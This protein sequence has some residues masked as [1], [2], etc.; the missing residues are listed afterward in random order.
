MSKWQFLALSTVLMLALYCRPVLSEEKAAGSVDVHR[1]VRDKW[2]LVVGVG[3]Y[4][5]A[6]VPKLKFASKDARDFRNFLVSEAHFAPDH[7]RL[8]LDEQA[9]QRRVLSE[10]GNK[11]LARVARPDDLVV[12]YFSSHGSASQADIRGRNFIVAYDTDPEDLFTT[13]IE[14]DK[15]VESI[16]S[17]VLSDRVLLVLDA[18]HSGAIAAGSKGLNRAGNFDAEQ[19]AQGTGQLVIC[20][21]Q[22]DQQSWESKR[23]DNGIFTRKLL[24]GLRLHGKSTRLD[25]AYTHLK[26]SVAEEVQQDY[27][28]R[29]NPSLKSFWKGDDLVLALLPQN[30]QPVPAAV[31][32]ILEP[33]STAV[34]PAGNVPPAK[35]ASAAGPAVS[36]ATYMQAVRLYK[37]GDLGSA[38][39]LFQKCVKTTYATD[40]DAR[41][42]L[43]ACLLG[44]NRIPEALDEFRK[45]YVLKPHGST[46][47]YCMKILNHY[48]GTRAGA[49]VTPAAASTAEHANAP[50]GSPR[51]A[52]SPHVDDALVSQLKRN[53]PRIPAYHRVTPLLQDVINWS[54][55]DKANYRYD[56]QA[57]VDTAQVNL[58]DAEELLKKA[59]SMVKSLVPATKNYGE[60]ETEFQQRVAAG[61]ATAEQLL[62]PYRQ[63]IQARTTAI[64]DENAV[65]ET[66]LT[67]YN[68]LQA[69]YS[70]SYQ[71][72]NKTKK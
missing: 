54:T 51:I 23:Y 27:A 41:Y 3:N 57:R 30:S 28:Q 48:S 61:Q 65:L 72:K 9:T 69:Q 43:A 38:A 20:S 14:M 67:A 11:F 64:A 71:Y 49:Q 60:S 36:Q 53:L 39:G 1:P 50:A 26:D 59:E 21:S 63:A 12:L 70:N 44:M 22:T 42:Y 32:Q 8:L 33:D 37:K 2:A 4:Q 46:A 55:E 24:E 35:P 68:T 25:D 13:G 40:P 16:K 17:R 45:C 5:N 58:R 7:V 56:A 66:C 10:L 19:I 31:R 34:R 52:G 15:I 47:A 18:C 29:Q 62:V 6:Q